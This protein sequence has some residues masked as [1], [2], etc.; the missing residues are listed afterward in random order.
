MLEF[1][2][3]VYNC[4]IKGERLNYLCMGKNAYSINLKLTE[5]ENYDQSDEIFSK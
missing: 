3:F 5:Y 4:F 1:E 2:Q